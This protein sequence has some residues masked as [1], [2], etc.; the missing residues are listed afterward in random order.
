MRVD[1]QPACRLEV[2]QTQPPLFL[3]LLFLQ[4][5]YLFL[6]LLSHRYAE[7]PGQLKFYIF[8]LLQHDFLILLKFGGLN[9]LFPLLL[10]ILSIKGLGV[11]VVTLYLRDFEVSLEKLSLKA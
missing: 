7:S 3:L 9:L 2:D 1:L 4:F 6:G 11:Q 5:H 8:G 10:S